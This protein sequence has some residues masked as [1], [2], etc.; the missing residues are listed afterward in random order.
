MKVSSRKSVLLD[1]VGACVSTLC[2]VHCLL[3]GLAMGIL[4]VAGLE[5]LGNPW[6]EATFIILALSVGT[7]AMLHGIRRHHSYIPSMVFVTGLAMIVG[8]HFAGHDSAS[9]P[10]GTVLAVCGGLSIASF[11]LLNQRLQHRNCRCRNKSDVAQA[12]K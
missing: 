7:W 2:A 12:V 4:A 6:V 9:R 8:S 10:W 1:R 5:F 3:T 11:H